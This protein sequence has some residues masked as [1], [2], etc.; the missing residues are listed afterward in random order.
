MMGGT[1]DF[2]LVQGRWCLGI[3]S[4]A[5][6]IGVLWTTAPMKGAKQCPRSMASARMPPH[7]HLD[8]LL[9]EGNESVAVYP[10]TSRIDERFFYGHLARLQ[11]SLL[12]RFCVGSSRSEFSPDHRD[13]LCIDRKYRLKLSRCGA[14]AELQ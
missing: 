8:Q 1:I 14:N 2:L 10:L 9:D 6:Q 12:V 4:H 13:L 5:R 3:Q 11:Q 7:L